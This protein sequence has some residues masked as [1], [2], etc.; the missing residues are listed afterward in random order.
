[1]AQV[2]KVS[3]LA[4]NYPPESTGIAPYAGSL[5]AGLAQRGFLVT[6][7]VAHPHYPEWRIYD[8]Y[9]QWSSDAILDAVHVYRRRHYVPRSPQGW[10]R[11]FSELTY[12]LRLLFVRLNDQDAVIAISPSLFATALWRLRLKFMLR[13]P[14]FIVWVQDIYT[15]GLSETNQGSKLTARVMRWVEQWTLQAADHLV[16]IHQRFADYSINGLNVD[17]SKVSV[18]RNWT[19]L[20]AM[21]LVDS[22]A[23]R[24]HLG[25]PEDT[26]IAVHTGNMGIKQGLENIVEAAR[27]ADLRLA[28]VHFILVGDGSQKA[29]LLELAH[30]V[31]RV[32]FIEP[33]DDEDYQF[34]LI[35]ADVLVVN[36]KLGVSEMAV[37]SKLTSY[38]HA[39]RPIVGAT[40]IDGITASEIDDAQAGVVVPAGRPD[41]LLD[42]VLELA[43]DKH[44]AAQLGANGRH[45]QQS[46]LASAAAIHRWTELIRSCLKTRSGDDYP[47]SRML[48]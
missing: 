32:T 31:T 23:A 18:I 15:L 30:G 11:L 26:T 13:K 40:D 34:A 42:A 38:F 20:G 19:H 28:A 6:A 12:G 29:N 8:G 4:L 2:R 10:R 48:D 5:A 45:Y 47:I 9:G 7:H 36:E 17:S 25:W 33:L 21:P 37:P 41:L 39:G 22:P 27:I 24:R 14:I 16:V 3:I 46:V 43:A 44:R 1:M 35:A